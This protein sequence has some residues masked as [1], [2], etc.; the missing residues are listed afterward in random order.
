MWDK[1]VEAHK[2]KQHYRI[3]NFGIE[4]T[5]IFKLQCDNQSHQT[6]KNE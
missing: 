5:P 1:V 4:K 6:N 3:P 2:N